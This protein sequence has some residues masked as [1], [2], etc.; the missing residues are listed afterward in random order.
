MWQ[1][2][3]IIITTCLGAFLVNLLLNL[4]SLHRLGGIDDRMPDT[5]PLISVLVPARN[6]ER[7]IRTCLDSLRRQDYPNYEILVLDDR[8]DDRTAPIVEE[9]ARVDSRV[10]LLRGAPLPDGWAGKPHACF[11]LANAAKG[12]WFLFT[13]ADTT[14]APSALRS[15]LSYAAKNKL[16][17][18]SGF[19]YQR[20]MSVSQRVTMPAIYFIILSCIPLWFAQRCSKPRPGIAI[21]QFLFV[22]ADDYRQIGGHTVVKNRILEDVWLSFEMVRRGKKQAMVDLSKVVDC[23]MYENVGQLW[24]G[25]AKWIY[26]V[27]TLAPWIIGFLVAAVAGLFIIPFVL[28]AWH[29]GPLSDAHLSALIIMQVCFIL[30]MRLLIDR[31]FGHS[32]LYSLSHPLGISFMLAS[33]T[34]G[35][36]RKFTGAGVKWKSRTYKPD[37]KVG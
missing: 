11:Q 28:M 36:L 14:H 15:A 23:R 7:T 6:E 26:S 25:F 34:Y 2:Y 9:V 1:I 29:L 22:N 13:D 21:G 18:I 8:S 37:S 27:A 20:T 16:S 5:T 19:P 12:I 30:I 10:K 24:E 4:R 32:R 3:Q 31:R 17:L 33:G 35:S